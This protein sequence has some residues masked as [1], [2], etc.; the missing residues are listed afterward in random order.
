MTGKGREEQIEDLRAR[1]AGHL[2]VSCRERAAPAFGFPEDVLIDL[3]VSRMAAWAE[4]D[5]AFVD[6]W[7]AGRRAASRLRT[8]EVPLGELKK[9]TIEEDTGNIRHETGRFFTISGVTARHRTRAGE[10]VWDQP[11][12]D[13]PEIGILGIAAKKLGGVLHFCLHAKEEPGNLHGVQLSP[14]VQATYSNYTRAHG[15]A[16]PAFVGI[17]LDPPRERVLF[18][19]LQTEDGGRFLFKSNRNMIV[20]VGRDELGDLPDGYLWLTLRQIVVLLRRDN[21]VNACARSV[22]SC[23]L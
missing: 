15:G 3:A 23:L 7:I 2:A 17:F 20:L 8:E 18:A 13:Q 6:R 10:L 21:L 9:W 22:L 1:L 14:T 5:D 4:H 12:I 16:V 11:I 19:K